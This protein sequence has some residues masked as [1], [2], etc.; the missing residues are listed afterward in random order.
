MQLEV[1]RQ[2][3][4]LLGDFGGV[5]AERQAHFMDR[6]IGRFLLLL[7]LLQLASSNAGGAP[8]WTRTLSR[9]R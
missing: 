7:L 8:E 4:L 6:V 3:K 9:L 1:K 5:V 2:R